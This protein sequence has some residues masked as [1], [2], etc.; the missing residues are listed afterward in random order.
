MICDMLVRLRTQMLT[1][2]DNEQ[3]SV[4][5][6]E[7]QPPVATPH[8]PC[9]Y[10]A[11]QQQE[12]EDDDE[13]EN[14]KQYDVQEED[15]QEMEADL[16]ESGLESSQS[17]SSLIS[18]RQS[19][20]DAMQQ[21]LI[22]LSNDSQHKSPSAVRSRKRC[23]SA[24]QLTD[25]SSEG[26]KRCRLVPQKSADA[27]YDAQSVLGGYIALPLTMLG[28]VDLNT[29]PYALNGYVLS[30]GSVLLAYPTQLST[31]LKSAGDVQESLANENSLPLVFVIS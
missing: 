10:D 3:C 27:E 13:Q 18:S 1:S 9:K 28:A 25:E 26:D 11:E 2:E 6:A 22:D 30:N 29:M 16:S 8:I 14:R 24:A 5:A 17:T 7:E 23:H 15:A 20:A 4:M 12:N 21:K 19:D 31:S